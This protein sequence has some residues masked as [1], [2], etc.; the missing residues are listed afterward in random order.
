MV[1]VSL[2]L[3]LEGLSCALMVDYL[4]ISLDLG[5]VF[6]IMLSCFQVKDCCARI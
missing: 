1:G 5:M 3:A 6:T 2:V 4:S